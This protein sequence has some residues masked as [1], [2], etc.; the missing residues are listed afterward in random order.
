GRKDH[1]AMYPC[2]EN[3]PVVYEPTDGTA[4]APKAAPPVK[5]GA[6][7]VLATILV[8]L[9]PRAFGD[10][11]AALP[12][13]GTVRGLYAGA[14]GVPVSVNLDFGWPV[15]EGGKDRPFR[16]LNGFDAPIDPVE[17]IGIPKEP[18]QK[19]APD[20]TSNGKATS[21]PTGGPVTSSGGGPGM[22]GMG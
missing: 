19:E 21:R 22:P 3:I 13:A 6:A 15:G 9:P 2:P 10:G 16:F 5:P 20:S 18:G 7:D 4:A 11:G 14:F 8:H 17:Q 1:W 12:P